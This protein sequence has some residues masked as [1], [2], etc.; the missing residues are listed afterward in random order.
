[1][2]VSTQQQFIQII[3]EFFSSNHWLTERDYSVKNTFLVF[4][5]VV[6]KGRLLAN[7]SMKRATSPCPP[8]GLTSARRAR[9][10]TALARHPTSA[11]C[12][13]SVRDR[14]KTAPGT[15]P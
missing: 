2:G 7:P 14:R 15:S 8:L 6:D 13:R 4:N 10:V 11:L 5:E 9:P 3:G 1:M 12:N